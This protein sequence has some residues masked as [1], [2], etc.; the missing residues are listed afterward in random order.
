MRSEKEF[1]QRNE[2]NLKTIASLKSEIDQIK[3]EMSN[4]N[5]DLQE[6][7]ADNNALAEM[8]EHR[9][10]EITRLKNE[11]ANVFEKARKLKDEK[12]GND[13]QVKFF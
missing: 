12:L 10:Y 7:K 3:A 8:A 9:D 4:Q 6:L 11:L 5:I 13:D 2:I 1:K